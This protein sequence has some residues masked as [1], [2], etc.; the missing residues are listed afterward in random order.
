MLA[1]FEPTIRL[2]VHVFVAI[3]PCKASRRQCR[4]SLRCFAGCGQMSSTTTPSGLA[5]FMASLLSDGPT[6]T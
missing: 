3:M 1:G 2:L 4:S 6:D 5:L